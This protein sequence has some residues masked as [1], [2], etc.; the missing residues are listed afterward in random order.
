MKYEEFK[1]YNCVVVSC[2]IQLPRNLERLFRLSNFTLS[3]SLENI[4]RAWQSQLTPHRIIEQNIKTFSDVLAIS[5]T[6][7]GVA[8]FKPIINFCDIRSW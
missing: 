6:A 3:K 1:P 4:D 8:Q 2:P 7:S 5:K